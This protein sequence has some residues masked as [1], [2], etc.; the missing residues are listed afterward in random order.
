M[1]K[2]AARPRNVL[3][4]YSY[5]QTDTG[6]PRALMGL[7][8][9]LDRSRFRPLLLAHGRGPL[10]DEMGR[11]GVALLEARAGQL[12]A[13]HP[14]R[15]WSAIRRQM[16]LLRRERID[17]VHL[18]EFGWNL[19]LVAAA[20]LLRIPVVLHV[21]NPLDVESRNLHRVIAR[22]VVFVSEAHRKES[23]HLGRLRGDTAVLYNAVDVTRVEGG[24]SLRAELGIPSTD[25]VVGT[26]AQICHRKGMD[27][28]VE[29][30]R[31]VV[32]VRADV[33]FLVV[34]RAGTGE[35]DY[36]ARV[37]AAA[38][39]PEL[40]GRITFLGSRDDVPDLLASM[41][42]FFLPT[43]AETFGIVVIEAMAAGVPVV[44]TRVG[45]IPEIVS[46]P[47]L[48]SLVPPEDPDASAAALLEL[49]DDADRRATVGAAGRRSLP[50]RFDA[51]AYAAALHRLYEAVLAPA[52]R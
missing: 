30:A 31:R 9:V 11:R 5:L 22:Q 36:A 4:Y 47:D 14:V 17:L 23:R 48:G 35:E 49:L 37:Y 42:L 38:A 32:A 40:R 26:V 24:R 51:P 27:V 21:H 18:N 45:G 20:G 33:R 41:D 25:L 16:A 8:E 1:D 2:P 6:S 39:A 29:A 3:Y 12:S 19:D 15:A 10:V 50:G 13:R 46:T 44:A 28:F 52:S 34:G 7:V 43:R